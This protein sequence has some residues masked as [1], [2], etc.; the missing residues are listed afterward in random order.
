MS[1]DHRTQRETEPLNYGGRA[2]QNRRQSIGVWVAVGIAVGA[3]V[4]VSSGGIGGWIISGALVGAVVG[5][6]IP[7]RRS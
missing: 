1:I 3:L 5:A 4:G 6:V 2:M 7:K